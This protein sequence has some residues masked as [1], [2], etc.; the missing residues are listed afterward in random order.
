MVRKSF[1][2]SE[3]VIISSFRVCPVK[4]VLD[5]CGGMS[6]ERR[7]FLWPATTHAIGA[8]NYGGGDGCNYSN[9][10]DSPCDSSA[11][12]NN[13]AQNPS[14][15][16]GDDSNKPTTHRDSYPSKSSPNRPNRTPQPSTSFSTADAVSASHPDSI[17]TPCDN[18]YTYWRT[19]RRKKWCQ[20]IF[21]SF[22]EDG[23]GD[24][25]P[26]PVPISMPFAPPRPPTYAFPK[27]KAREKKN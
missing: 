6:S 10:A 25:A 5:R 15:P 7:A 14:T 3:L 18:C 1:P 21:R 16:G 27:A 19:K 20:F 17:R 13:S 24:A 26:T 4:G 11:A 2:N 8:E 22:Y 12:N 9:A 23:H